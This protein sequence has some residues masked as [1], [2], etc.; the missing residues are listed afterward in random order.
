V[1]VKIGTEYWA[2]ERGQTLAQKYRLSPGQ[3]PEQLA[4][5]IK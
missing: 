4:K 2:V 5:L 1:I 3:L